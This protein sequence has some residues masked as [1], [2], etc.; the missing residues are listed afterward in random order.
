ML[1]NQVTKWGSPN[2]CGGHRGR[3]FTYCIWI[4]LTVQQVMSL[5]MKRQRWFIFTL[6]DNFILT[7]LLLALIENQ[8]SSNYF[9]YFKKIGVLL[10]VKHPNATKLFAPL[11]RLQLVGN[12]LI[13]TNIAI[14]PTVGVKHLK[15]NVKQLFHFH[16]VMV[17]EL[18]KMHANNKIEPVGDCSREHKKVKYQDDQFCFSLFLRSQRSPLD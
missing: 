9:Y 18:F 5:K 12:F 1:N 4:L 14:F 3:C 15:L 7:E 10:F 6:L 8:G 17:I 2:W 13:W 16:F 11:F